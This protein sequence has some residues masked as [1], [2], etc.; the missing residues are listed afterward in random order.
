MRS[1]TNF[2]KFTL[3]K[4]ETI[5][6]TDN[7]Y[8][9]FSPVWPEENFEGAIISLTVDGSEIAIL[10]LLNKQFVL[11]VLINYL[12]I[13]LALLAHIMYPEVIEYVIKDTYITSKMH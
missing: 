13:Q 3:E 4:G 11:Q 1:Y 5:S 9:R 8:V 6:V 7:E 2:G 12:K 10:K